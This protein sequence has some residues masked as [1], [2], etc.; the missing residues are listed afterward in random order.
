MLEQFRRFLVIG[1]CGL[2]G[3]CCFIQRSEDAGISA[4]ISKLRTISVRGT[5]CQAARLD[6][7]EDVFIERV[8]SDQSKQL[9][10]GERITFFLSARERRTTAE[11][12]KD[13]GMPPNRRSHGLSWR[14]AIPV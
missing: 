8:A 5:K 6:F 4:G 1:G 7:T 3:D 10:L 11:N 13:D 9:A 2:I 12:E 14:I